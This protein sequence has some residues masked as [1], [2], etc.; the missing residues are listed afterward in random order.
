MDQPKPIHM[1]IFIWMSI[2]ILCMII[3]SN[4]NMTALRSND[5]RMPILSEDHSFDTDT[6]FTYNEID[7][8]N[9]SINDPSLTD[10]FRVRMFHR[11]IYFSIGDILIIGS[12]FCLF[13]STGI[14]VN[15]KNKLKRINNNG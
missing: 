10:I 1:T 8:I 11:T 13:V 4:S 7:N 15:Y 5:C 3:G 12:L 14:I 2:G 9:V 6:H